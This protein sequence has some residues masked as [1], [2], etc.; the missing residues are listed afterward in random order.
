MREAAEALR[1][2]GAG[3]V[4]IHFKTGAVCLSNEGFCTCPAIDIPRERILGTTG[5]GD[6]FCA[7]AL[8]AIERG[9]RDPEIL[10]I[11]SI[12]ALGALL[13]PDATGGMKPL[14][15]LRKMAGKDKKGN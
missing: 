3:R 13:S 2:A 14:S 1:A 4:I 15:V 5:A 12:A 9:A 8:L 11:A 6:A 7:G 10:E